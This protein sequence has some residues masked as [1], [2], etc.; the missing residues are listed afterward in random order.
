MFYFGLVRQ[1]RSYFCERENLVFRRYMAEKMCTIIIIST[2]LDILG[3]NCQFIK[4]EKL[5]DLV[6]PPIQPGHTNTFIYSNSNTSCSHYWQPLVLSAYF[7]AL[8]LVSEQSAW[9]F[10]FVNFYYGLFPLCSH[11]LKE[12]F[13]I[14][15]NMLIRFLGES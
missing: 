4:L 12:L 5:Q 11:S 8:G 9:L 10:F 3:V 15:G 13:N 1:F 2:F 14:L 7:Q 6:P